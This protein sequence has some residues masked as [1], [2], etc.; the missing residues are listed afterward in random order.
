MR[1]FFLLERLGASIFWPRLEC[2]RGWAFAW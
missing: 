1:V 2:F